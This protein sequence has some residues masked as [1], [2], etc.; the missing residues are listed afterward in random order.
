MIK[1]K[2]IILAGGT[3]FMGQEL[4]GY[5]GKENDIIVLTRQQLHAAN[6]R[7]R[8]DQLTEAD[9]LRTRYVRWDG[10]R[11]DQWAQHLEGADILINLAGKSVNCRYTPRNKKEIL[12][13]RLHAT[14][15][16]GQAIRACQQPPKLWINASSATIYRHAED[17]AQDEFTG[18]TG[19]GFSV[20]VCQQ[21]EKAFFDET[22]PGTRQVALRMAITLGAGGVLIPYF[23]LLK[24]GCGGRQGSGK[25]MFSWVHIEDTC[26]M[27]EWIYT[28]HELNGVFNCAA[29]GPVT[30]A[31]LMATLREL[32]GTRVGLP[33]YR[34]MLQCG[35][36]LIGTETELVLKSRW[37]VPTRILS[38]G[39]RFTYPELKEALRVIINKVPRQQY[40]L[41]K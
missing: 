16:I 9:L 36:A 28:H 41:F 20:D 29:P 17:R 1:D 30:N 3:G 37:V 19:A 27:M 34:W 4:I 8:Y 12:D 39:F 32:T 26:R 6:N 10:Q 14:R 21:W 7:N 15:A 40:R 33:A 11:P 2:K 18:E 22:V 13:S 38:T 24:Y 5:F 35:A 25:Q 23:N 31:V